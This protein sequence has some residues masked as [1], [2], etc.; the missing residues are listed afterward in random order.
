VKSVPI[1]PEVPEILD[2]H[3]DDAV[4]GFKISLAPTDD[5][6]FPMSK[7]GAHLTTPSDPTHYKKFAKDLGK[8]VEDT[9]LVILG[10]ELDG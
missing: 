3:W 8:T 9:V 1:V 6:G 10:V 5:L 2:I 7:R 4:Y